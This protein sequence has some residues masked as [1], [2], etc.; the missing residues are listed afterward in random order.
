MMTPDV[1]FAQG[2][3]NEEP[4]DPRTSLKA[5][6]PSSALMQGTLFWLFQGGFKVSSGTVEWYR[7]S[8]G[9]LFDNSEIASPVI[10]PNKLA[11]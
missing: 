6:R 1:R 10:G 9:T 7:S 8:C 4:V 5:P 2:A 11:W 3:A